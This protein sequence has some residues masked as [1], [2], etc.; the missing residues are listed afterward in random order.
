M[1]CFSYL[2]DFCPCCSRNH[3]VRPLEGE[4]YGFLQG[5][6]LE[7]ERKARGKKLKALQKGLRF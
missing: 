6:I 1:T 2:V 7:H 3:P 4:G 5:Y